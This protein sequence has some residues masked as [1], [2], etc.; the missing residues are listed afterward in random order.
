M[1]VLSIFR[2]KQ[3]N[4]SIG[5]PRGS[6]FT[7]SLNEHVYWRNTLTHII[8]QIHLNLFAKAEKSV[9]S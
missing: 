2:L 1:V 6:I 4:E 9:V 8:L 3:A 7:N 5:D